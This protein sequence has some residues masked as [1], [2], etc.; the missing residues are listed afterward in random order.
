[1][2]LPLAAVNEAIAYSQ[3]DPPEL[4]E[5]QRR[6]EALMQAVGMNDPA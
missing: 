2:G 1:M 5:D 3:S 6:E 4:D